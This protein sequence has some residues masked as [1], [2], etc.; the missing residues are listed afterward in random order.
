MGVMSL[1]THL[2][3]DHAQEKEWKKDR[4]TAGIHLLNQFF[5]KNKR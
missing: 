2:Q 3:D 1:R 5:I 4:L